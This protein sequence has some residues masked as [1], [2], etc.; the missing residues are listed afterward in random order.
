MQKYAATHWPVG[1]LG[2]GGAGTDDWLAAVYLQIE[3]S[4]PMSPRSTR[5]KK[6]GFS[7]HPARVCDDLSRRKRKVQRRLSTC[8][9]G[10]VLCAFGI[11][12]VCLAGAQPAAD[13]NSILRAGR[14]AQSTTVSQFSHRQR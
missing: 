9:R 3:T 7:V 4:S 10:R 6:H 8:G 1:I 11:Q 5:I 13:L 12:T 2:G 14:A